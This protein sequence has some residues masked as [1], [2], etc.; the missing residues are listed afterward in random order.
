[1]PDFDLVNLDRLL[2]AVAAYE[3]KRSRDLPAVL[4]SSSGPPEPPPLRAGEEVGEFTGTY[5]TYCGGSRRMRLVARDDRCGR[6]NPRHIE[7]TARTLAQADIDRDPLVFA[8]ATPPPVFTAM[9]LQCRREMS[10]IVDAGPPSEVIVLGARASGLS[11]PHA[12]QAVAFFLEQAYRARTGGAYTAA[13]VMYRAALEQFLGEEGFRGA[14]L[15]AR[16][17]AA[18]NA[19]PAWVKQLDAD[20]MHALRSLGKEAV[21]AREGDLS[22]QTRLD[23]QLVHDAEILFLDVLDE[24]YEVP[25]RREQRRERVLEA[26]PRPPQ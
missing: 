13:T 12:P 17:D 8:I 5:C 2:G 18:I 19:S 24:V 4:G 21:H 7:R 6:L 22:G 16:I 9:C 1:V 26:R 14:T 20:L 3:E 23:Q 25:A 10:L 15:A 11:T